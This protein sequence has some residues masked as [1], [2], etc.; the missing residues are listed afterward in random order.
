MRLKLITSL[1][2]QLLA[3]QSKMYSS[4]IA[5]YEHRGA[6]SKRGLS[7]FCKQSKENLEQLRALETQFDSVVKLMQ[8][9]LECGL[10]R[11]RAQTKCSDSRGSNRA[12]RTVAKAKTVTFSVPVTCET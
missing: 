7:K 11:A 8:E 3:F 9:F 2:S 12:V 1:S 6:N 10:H 5:Y 4:M